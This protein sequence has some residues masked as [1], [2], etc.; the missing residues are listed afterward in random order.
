LV[1]CRQAPLTCRHRSSQYRREACRERRDGFLASGTSTPFGAVVDENEP[2]PNWRETRFLALSLPAA[3]TA[4][5][6]PTAGKDLVC[7]TVTFEFV[8]P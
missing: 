6:A 7:D 4:S 3:L 8:D 5:F 2:P 1:D